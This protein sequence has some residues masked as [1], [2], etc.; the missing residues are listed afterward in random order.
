MF[1]DIHDQDR[2]VVISLADEDYNQLVIEVENPTQTVE[3][4][5]GAVA[6]ARAG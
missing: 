3:A 2:T 6:A 4:I 1:W 5:N